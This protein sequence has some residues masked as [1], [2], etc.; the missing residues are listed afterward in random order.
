MR[1]L[2]RVWVALLLLSVI[3]TF[4]AGGGTPT[5]TPWLVAKF[6]LLTFLLLSL[7]VGALIEFRRKNSPR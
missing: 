4:G 1:H 6:G 7:I 3:L 5:T 2:T